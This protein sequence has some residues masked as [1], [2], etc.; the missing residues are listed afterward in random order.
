MYASWSAVIFC[1]GGSFQA[2]GKM[3]IA[4]VSHRRAAW[5]LRQLQAVA[6]P[7]DATLGG[8]VNLPGPGVRLVW[9]GMRKTPGL[10]LKGAFQK[11]LKLFAGTDVHDPDIFR[12]S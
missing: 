7:V 6:C 9:G 3:V 12:A 5:F 8:S 11:L 10:R 2:N 1:F 4:A